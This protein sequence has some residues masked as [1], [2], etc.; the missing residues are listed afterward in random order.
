VTS[1][2]QPG[3]VWRGAALGATAGR[4][5]HSVA[6]IGRL[7]EERVHTAVPHRV[8]VTG[9]VVAVRELGDGGIRFSLVDG[10]EPSLRLSCLLPADVV[11]DLR[12]TLLR[13]HD[14]DVLDIVVEG[15]TARAGGLLRYGFAADALVLGVSDLDPVPTEQGLIEARL[16]VEQAVRSADLA[17]G[18]RGLA[19]PTAPLRVGLVGLPDDPAVLQSADQLA[20]SS[21][22]VEVDVTLVAAHHASSPGDLARSVSASARG[23]DAVLILRGEGRPLALGIFDAPE[24]A[25]A[26]AEAPVPVVVGLGGRGQRTATDIVAGSS[27]PTAADAV[28]VVLARLRTAEEQLRVVAAE[29]SA[30]ADAAVTRAR[31]EL[32]TAR[33]E[34]DAALVDACVRAEATRG[35]RV[36]AAYLTAVALAIA[37]V[38]ATVS[39]GAPFLLLGLLLPAAVAVAVRQGLLATGTARPR[40]TRSMQLDETSF[41]DVMARLRS[42]R[43]ELVRTSSPEKV[44]RL[45][46]TADRLVE[47]GEQIL[48]RTGNAPSTP[49][50]ATVEPTRQLPPAEPEPA[51]GPAKPSDDGDT[52]AGEGAPSGGTPQNPSRPGA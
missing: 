22:Q 1:D 15:R 28:E 38:V 46:D 24:V 8:W 35:R 44:E 17:A 30:A 33:Q 37:V 25:R 31:N 3:R 41:D 9:R 27:Q 34:V 49:S 14:V 20:T 11:E 26:V 40:R 23:H 4:N 47:R 2:A 48:R 10:A 16:Q 7:I 36:L 13:G 12:E 42:V 39:A 32:Q 19:L 5:T 45:R 43:E 21:F 50:V 52:A 18:Q 6:G 51:A 29:V